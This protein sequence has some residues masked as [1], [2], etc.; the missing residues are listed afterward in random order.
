MKC[1]KVVVFVNTHVDRERGELFSNRERMISL[2]VISVSNVDEIGMLSTYVT[3][4]V[5]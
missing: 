5:F 1:E 4:T 2:D 3:F